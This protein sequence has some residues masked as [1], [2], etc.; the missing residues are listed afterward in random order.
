M[1]RHEFVALIGYEGESA[2]VDGRFARTHGRKESKELARDG[3]YK[4]ALS[5]AL[6]DDGD[7]GCERLLA[8]LHEQKLFV[9][10][11]IKEMYTLFGIASYREVKKVVNI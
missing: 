6:Y 3:Y 1:K 9:E 10:Y 8:W 4:A 5:A 11:T 2:I 7:A